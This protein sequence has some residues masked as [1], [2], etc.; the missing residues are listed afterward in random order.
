MRI[1]WQWKSKKT[2]VTMNKHVY[3]ESKNEMK[4]FRY[5]YIKPKYSNKTSL[6]YMDT[7]SFNHTYKNSLY[8]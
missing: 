7:D 6:C 4:H 3:L 8:L 5:D 2:Q 1:Y